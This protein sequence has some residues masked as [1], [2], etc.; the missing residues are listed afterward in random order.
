[1]EAFVALFQSDIRTTYIP[2]VD[3]HRAL[4]HA[5]VGAAQDMQN[6]HL[7]A[8]LHDIITVNYFRL[9]YYSKSY[10]YYYECVNGT[11]QHHHFDGLAAVGTTS[12]ESTRV[13]TYA[14][15]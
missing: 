11:I 2:L 10:E 5:A 15:P 12:F 1:M 7:S 8:K 6:L 3:C 4:A 9:D 14:S 13:L